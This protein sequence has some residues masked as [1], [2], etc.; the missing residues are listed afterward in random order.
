VSV[1]R[2]PFGL[3]S[4]LLLLSP[5]GEL[6]VGAEPTAASREGDVA[7]ISADTFLSSL[8]INIHVA[9]GYPASNY[10]E[11]LRYIGVRNVRDSAGHLAGLLRLHEETGVKI[12]LLL[13]CEFGSEISASLQLASAGALL[14]LEGPNEPNNFQIKYNGATGGGKGSWLPVA[15]CQRDLYKIAKDN[16]VL[17][18]YPVF[19]VSEGGAQPTN[20]GLQYLTIP[21]GAGTEMPDGTQYADYANAHNYVSSTKRS[22]YTDNQAWQAADPVLDDVWDGLYGEY[23]L[24]WRSHFKGYSEAQLKSLPRVT[25]ETGWDTHTNPGGQSVQGK[26]LVNTYLSQFKR[27]WSY[28]FIYELVDAEGSEGEQG[29]Y[30]AHYVPKLAATYIHNL[31]TILAD[32]GTGTNPAHLNYAIPN[33]PDTV[34]DLL[35][36]KENGAFELVVWGEAVNQSN[37]IALNFGTPHKTVKIYDVT[38]TTDPVRTYKDVRSLPLV[39]SDHAMIIE[40]ID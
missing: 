25:T 31:T 9:Q 18:A 2:I 32:K 17:R 34:H 5:T 16:T 4:I 19:G 22:L 36:Q 26:V 20:V 40:V 13:W 35:L 33:M 39:I 37:E 23:G 12:D 21:A 27:G 38:T 14:A 24:T 7:A 30:T 6:P 11:P 15:Q 1:S 28:T 10:I 8:G 29:L 3:A